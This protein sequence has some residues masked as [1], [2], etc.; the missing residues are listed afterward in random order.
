MKEELD[1]I[2]PT[3]KKYINRAMVKVFESNISQ[4]NK[5]IL[6]EFKEYQY[7][8]GCSDKRISKLF[9]MFNKLFHFKDELGNHIFSVDLDK[10]NKKDILKFISW[11][12]R[13]ED[14]AESTK[15]DYRKLIK[16]LYRWFKDEDKRFDSSDQDVR[17]TAKK[18]Y[19]YVE[20]EVIRS[21]KKD[22]INPT[23]LINDEDVELV[24]SKGCRT[25]KEKALIKFLHETGLRTTELLSMRIR[26]IEISAQYGTVHVN[27]KTGRRSVEFAKSKSHLAK[28]IEI[29]PFKDDP[30]HLVWLGESSNSMWKPLTQIGATKLIKRSFNRAGLNKKCNLH[31]FRHSRAS[32]NGQYWSEQ[33]MWEYF[34]WTAG[35]RMTSIYC[36]ISKKQQTQEFLKM[37]GLSKQTEED[38][39]KPIACTCG[40]INDPFSRYCFKCGNALKVEYLIQDKAK[41]NTETDKSVKLMMEMFKDPEMLKAFMEFKSNQK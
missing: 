40:E 39:N 23:E 16:Q 15:S 9:A 36:H 34:G 33:I 25:V 35:S 13:Q 2:Y 37:N 17:K 3:R 11:I 26:D 6:I 20:K 5:D 38:K 24:I 10:A 28:W 22:R 1:R 31:W 19:N 4:R 32:I 41:I 29:H 12:N 14:Y 21:Y 8:R 7:S 30:N 18:M 27:G